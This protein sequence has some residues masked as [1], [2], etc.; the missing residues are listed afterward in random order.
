MLAPPAA[1]T[2]SGCGDVAR[3]CRHSKVCIVTTIALCNPGLMFVDHI[4]FQYNGFL[5]GLLL[6]SVG[7]IRRVRRATGAMTARATQRVSV[8]CVRRG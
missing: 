4:H 6:V 2:H 8:G 7:L 3:A 1:D 5:I